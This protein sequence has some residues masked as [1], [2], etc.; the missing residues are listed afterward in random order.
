[1][2]PTF[3]KPQMVRG[4]VVAGER[5]GMVSKNNDSCAV[6]RTFWYRHDDDLADL[7][8]EMETLRRVFSKNHKC[9]GMILTFEYKDYRRG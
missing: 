5:D 4:V 1:M 6:A 7:E 9:S 8:N 3:E 2:K